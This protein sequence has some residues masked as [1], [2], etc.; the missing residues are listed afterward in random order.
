MLLS[1][2]RQITSPAEAA[3]LTP[4]QAEIDAHGE[5]IAIFKLVV[6]FDTS[7]AHGY[8]QPIY[9]A[10]LCSPA[11]YATSRGASS[12]FRICG[13]ELRGRYRSVPV[14]ARAEGEHQ[15]AS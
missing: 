2:V 8:I 3:R 6:P 13:Y 5:D 12:E 10:I 7:L 1:E 11:T 9:Q 4:V 14:E 15:H